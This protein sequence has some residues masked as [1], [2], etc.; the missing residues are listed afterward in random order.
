MTCKP[1]AASSEGMYG[2]NKIEIDKI[3]ILGNKSQFDAQNNDGALE[4][5]IS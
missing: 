3:N 2:Q 1:R 4:V 5:Y